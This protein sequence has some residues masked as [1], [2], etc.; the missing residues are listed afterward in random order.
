[1]D[2]PGKNRDYW[3]AVGVAVI[4]VLVIANGYQYYR[5]QDLE[6]RH[7]ALLHNAKQLATTVGQLEAALKRQQRKGEDQ[8]QKHTVKPAGA[9]ESRD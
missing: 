4:A 7:R 9:P 2:A 8:Q 6:A 3:Q 1:M 5:Y